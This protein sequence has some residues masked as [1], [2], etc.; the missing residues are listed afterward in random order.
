[1]DSGPTRRR[2][3][4]N[5]DSSLLPV[6][7]QRFRAGLA[8]PRAVLLEARQNDLV[9]LVHMSPA[10]PRD[11]P[12]TPRIRPSALRDGRGDDEK[13]GNW[14]QKSGHLECLYAH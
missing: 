1:M 5:D 12:R 8:E 13:K 9:A 14:E 4:R 2:V 7:R 11:I 3:S 6:I 10:K